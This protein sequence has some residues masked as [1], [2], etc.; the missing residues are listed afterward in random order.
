MSRHGSHSGPTG[1]RT[2]RVAETAPRRSQVP[3]PRPGSRE[4]D[5]DREDEGGLRG[6]VIRAGEL[7]ACC[8]T[9]F[10]MSSL[11][12]AALVGVAFLIYTILK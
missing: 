8:V 12:M 2:Q 6:A 1:T 10:L 9:S 11:V 4:R 3:R 7:S 5:T